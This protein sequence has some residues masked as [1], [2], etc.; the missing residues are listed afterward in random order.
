MWRHDCKQLLNKSTVVDFYL[1]TQYHMHLYSVT[2]SK[3]IDLV[4]V[5]R[6]IHGIFLAYVI[7]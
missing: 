4:A 3:N 7:S 2:W 6:I 5:S 1:H